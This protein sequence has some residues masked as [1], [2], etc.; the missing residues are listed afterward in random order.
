MIVGTPGTDTYIVV[1]N[2]YSESKAF[3]DDINNLMK[4]EGYVPQGGL[5]SMDQN[6]FGNYLIQAMVYKGS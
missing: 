2:H 6:A 5:S 3:V 4:K 1:K